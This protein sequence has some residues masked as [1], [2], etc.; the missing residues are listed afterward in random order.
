MYYVYVLKSQKPAFI[1]VGSTPDLDRRLREHNNKA[2]ESTKC[3]VPLKLIYYEAFLDKRDAI[4]REKKLKHHG[5]VIGYLK[6]RLINSLSN[7]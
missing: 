3:H 6:K 7:G 4:N 5:S 1:Y 2:V